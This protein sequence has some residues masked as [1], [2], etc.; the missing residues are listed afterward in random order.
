L[1]DDSVVRIHDRWLKPNRRSGIAWASLLVLLGVLVALYWSGNLPWLEARG[2]GEPAGRVMVLEDCDSD[3]R[4]PPF[5]DAVITFGQDGKPVRKVG[6]LNI[7]QTVG[8]CRSLAVSPDSRFF[9]VCEN[10]GNKLTAYQWNTGERLWS[11]KAESVSASDFTSATVAPNGTVYALA[12][13]GTIYGA[14]ALAIDEKGRI[15]RQA[16]VGGFDLVLD[17]DRSVL[18]L[19]G[20]DVKK[21]DLELKLLLELKPVRWCAVS[22]DVARD[23]SVWV[24]ERHHPDVGQSTNRLLKISPE[25]RILQTIGLAFEPLCLRVDRS[26]GSVWVTGVGVSESTTTR[27]LESIEKRTGRLPT[28]KQLRAYLTR[29][30]VRPRTHKYDGNGALQCEMKKGG[31]SLDLDP[32]DGSAW[33]GGCEKVYHYSR[34]GALLGQLS[35]LAS[36]QKY[37]VVV[38][39]AHGSV[40]S[41]AGGDR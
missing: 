2:G 39:D 17:A 9:T 34:Q 21:C 8:G 16:P 12:S 27:L 36:D 5:E 14:T 32:A 4:A 19:V 35:G 18:W 40:T 15:I 20:D 3:Y 29:P 28:G 30:I 37:V 24:A 22:V 7:C 38:P 23:G 1:P 10:V 13:K 11:V 31:F 26:E 25:G 6:D 33:I 41:N